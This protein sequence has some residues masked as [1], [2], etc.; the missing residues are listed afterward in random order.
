MADGWWNNYGAISG[1]IAAYAPIY[2]ASQ[3]ASYSNLFNPGTYDLTTSDAPSWAT[4]SGW[5]PA[6]TNYLDTG[7][8]AGS[9]YSIIARVNA[10]NNGANARVWA[11]QDSNLYIGSFSWAGSLRQMAAGGASTSNHGTPTTGDQSVAIAGTTAYYNGTAD[12]TTVAS[13]TLP[14]VSIYLLNNQAKNRVWATSMSA[15]A[16]YSSTVSATDIATLHTLI[17]SLTSAGDP[18]PSGQPT[19]KRFLSVPFMGRGAQR[20]VRGSF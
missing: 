7:I 3:A 11:A 1:C 14:S 8:V 4:T 9:G 18:G 13:G 12:G 5:S 6:S 2:A 19:S 16:L 17:M 10:V 15:C 20:V